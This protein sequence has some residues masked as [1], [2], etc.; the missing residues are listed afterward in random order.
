M[1]NGCGL[2]KKE[3]LCSRKAIEALFS[4]STDSKSLSV[5]PIRAVFK[6]TE[7]A[8]TRI[9]VSVSKKRFRHAVDRNRVKRQLREQFRLNKHI[10]ASTTSGG[11]DLA[12]IWLTNRLQPSSLIQD[13]MVCLLNKIAQD[14]PQRREQTP[15]QQAT[16]AEGAQA[17]SATQS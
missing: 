2:S 6:H 12:F 3:R 4:T 7:E 11:M 16:S 15:A 13:K 17:V 9:L 8:G 1:G 14:E 10:L 5:Y